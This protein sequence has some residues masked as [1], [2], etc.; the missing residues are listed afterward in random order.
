MPSSSGLGVTRMSERPLGSSGHGLALERN[1][2][3]DLSVREAAWVLGEPARSVRRMCKQGLLGAW[4]V[5]DPSGS[6]A[7]LRWHVPSEGLMPLLRTQLARRRLAA[8][9]AGEVAAPPRTARR[10]AASNPAP[11]K[12]QTTLA[13]IAFEQR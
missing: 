1:G 3:R 5:V 10:E 8:L 4:R 7:R 9:V 6:S 13:S 12:A 2:R 11:V